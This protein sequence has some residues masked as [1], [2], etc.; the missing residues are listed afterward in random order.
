M[1]SEFASYE[2]LKEQGASPEMIDLQA[3]RD[4]IDPIRRIRLLRS[5]FGVSLSD[6][7]RAMTPVD[8]LSQPQTV[9]VG[10][11]VYWEG[12]DTVQGEWI[13]QATVQRIDADRVIVVDHH[14]FLVTRDGLQ[15]THV[16]DGLTEIPRSYFEK[17]LVERLADTRQF[18]NR[19]AAECRPAS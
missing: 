2:R 17:S 1:P 14:K 13:M 16:T 18:W 8:P 15:E 9:A 12:C 5:L 4:G 6:A 19:L 11:T 7:K 3:R 10:G